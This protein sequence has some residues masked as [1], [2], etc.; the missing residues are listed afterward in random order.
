MFR[1]AFTPND[2]FYVRWHDAVPKLA[3]DDWRLRVAGPGVVNP[4]E[5][6]HAELT[7]RFRTHEVAAVNQCS[8][9][10]R[11]LFV[12]D[13]PGVQWGYGAM[14]NAAWL[15]VRLK[16]V[17]EDAGLAGNALE[18]VGNGA[19]T[20]ML[21]GPDKGRKAGEPTD[22]NRLPDSPRAMNPKEGGW[23]LSRYW[24]CCTSL[25]GCRGRVIAK[26]L[27]PLLASRASRLSVIGFTSQARWRC[28]GRLKFA[29][30]PFVGPLRFA[31]SR[32]CSP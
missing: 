29:W 24:V 27:P 16:D 31:G 13:V 2:A 8:G 6:T 22:M 18:V 11:G 10:R 15:G 26:A 32:G 20:A 5:F 4:R 3:R 21:T 28:R 30:A 25:K 9:N 14:G 1:E 23:R 7:R 12:P 17:L 19:D